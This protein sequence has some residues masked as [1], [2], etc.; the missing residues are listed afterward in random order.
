MNRMPVKWSNPKFYTLIVFKLKPD[1]NE[2]TSRRRHQ[3]KLVVCGVI[4]YVLR[5]IAFYITSN[6][7]VNDSSFYS[8]KK[9]FLLKG[10]STV[11]NI[12]R[13][14]CTTITE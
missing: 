13:F 12:R 5:K 1:P 2:N 4:L 14:C 8:N 3:I 6:T 11:C 9:K 7:D 10:S